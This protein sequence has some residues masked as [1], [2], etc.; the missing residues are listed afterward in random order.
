MSN[1]NNYENYQVCFVFIISSPYVFGSAE[2]EAYK[3]IEMVEK[4][5]CLDSCP[6]FLC[7]IGS[8]IFGLLAKNI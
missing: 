3:T 2:Q 4:V 1:N 6:I 5:G 7:L 8:S